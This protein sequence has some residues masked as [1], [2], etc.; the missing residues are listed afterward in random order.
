MR[1][2]RPW[3]LYYSGFALPLSFLLSLYISPSVSL[4]LPLSLPLC[5]VCSIGCEKLRDLRPTDTCLPETRLHTSGVRDGQKAPRE[6]K[7]TWPRSWDSE[8]GRPGVRNTGS[9]LWTPALETWQPCRNRSTNWGRGRRF[10]TK[11]CTEMMA[12]VWY[13]F[14]SRVLSARAD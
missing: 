3:R 9:S 2:R 13:A 11:K 6:G 14:L 4:S 8:P 10:F 5:Y 7:G 1:R 12:V